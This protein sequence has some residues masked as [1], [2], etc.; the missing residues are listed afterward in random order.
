M[1]LYYLNSIALHTN[2]IVIIIYLKISFQHHLLSKSIDFKFF[3]RIMQRYITKKPNI[4]YEMY[5]DFLA[6][7]TLNETTGEKNYK[8][9]KLIL[10]I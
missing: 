2:I 10:H 7:K 1:Y 6:E 4:W 9:A 3:I 5:K 8:H